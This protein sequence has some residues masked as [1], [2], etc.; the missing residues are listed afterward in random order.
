MRPRAAI[1][2]LVAALVVPA[3]ANART[4]LNPDTEADGI[5]ASIDQ[6][7]INEAKTYTPNEQVLF[8]LYSCPGYPL[9]AGCVTLA[10]SRPVG[11]WTMYI[12]PDQQHD[13]VILMHEVGHIYD[14]QPSRK[15]HAYRQIF[16][17]ANHLH[18]HWDIRLQELWA[19]NYA[20]CA[21]GWTTRCKGIPMRPVLTRR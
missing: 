2:T 21:T 20:D 9:A 18:G 13:N 1:T 6:A 3:A 17:N 11:A 12:R 16:K 15:V 19:I 7:V 14:L 4:I 10:P 8:T 5:P